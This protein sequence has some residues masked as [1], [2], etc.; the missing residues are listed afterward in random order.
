M[1]TSLIE[2]VIWWHEPDGIVS[3]RIRIRDE[4]IEKL[5]AELAAIK[6]MH[7]AVERVELVLYAYARWSHSSLP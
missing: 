3:R 1:V 7:L 2:K 4:K 5:S 6:A